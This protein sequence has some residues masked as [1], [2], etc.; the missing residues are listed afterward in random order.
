VSGDWQKP[1]GVESSGAGTA[2]NE[3][4]WR[5][6]GTAGAVEVKRGEVRGRAGVGSR[7]LS[8]GNV[9]GCPLY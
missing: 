2:N 8:E 1:W 5:M 9:S 6:Q 7:W 4:L 3:R